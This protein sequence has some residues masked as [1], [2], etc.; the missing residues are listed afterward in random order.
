MSSELQKV[1][2]ERAENHPQNRNTDFPPG[3]EV[4]IN[5]KGTLWRNSGRSS[6]RKY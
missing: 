2:V 6:G 5:E 3:E 4:A 1:M